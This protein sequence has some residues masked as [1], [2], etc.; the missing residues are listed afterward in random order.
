MNKYGIE[1]IEPEFPV[2]EGKRDLTLDQLLSMGYIRIAVADEFDAIMRG[3][4][5]YD[6]YAYVYRYGCVRYSASGNLTD[7]YASHQFP[8]PETVMTRLFPYAKFDY[9]MH[10]IESMAGA[11][12]RTGNFFFDPQVCKD[13]GRRIIYPIVYNLKRGDEQLINVFIA[14]DRVAGKREFCVMQFTE[15]GYTHRLSERWDIPSRAKAHSL[16]MSGTY[17]GK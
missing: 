2:G 3:C 6:D 13:S 9:P 8:S 17:F 4:G 1:M 12:R 11:S 5:I 16:I 10:S 14:S 7:I 15:T